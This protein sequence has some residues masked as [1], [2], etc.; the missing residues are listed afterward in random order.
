MFGRS[1]SGRAFRCKSSLCCGLS[2]AIPNVGERAF[3]VL[4]LHLGARAVPSRRPF[5]TIPAGCMAEADIGAEGQTEHV[6]AVTRNEVHH[7]HIPCQTIAFED[8]RE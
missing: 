3:T 7:R 6:R 5:P 4:R 1:P 2:P 8:E